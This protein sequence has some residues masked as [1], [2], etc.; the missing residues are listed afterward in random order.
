MEALKIYCSNCGNELSED[1]KVCTRCGTPVKLE[2][3]AETIIQSFQKD[4][5]LQDHWIRRLIAYF[6]DSIIVGAVTAILI[7]IAFFPILLTNA[8]SLVNLTTFPF[9]MGLLY[10]LYFPIAESTYGATFGKNLLGLR[11]VTKSGKKPS[12]EKAF[13]RN[14]SKIHQVLLLLDLVGGLVTSTDL[15]Q[16]YSDRIAG[17]TIV[18]DKSKGL[19]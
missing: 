16:K 18:L 11:V 14:I 8:A 10:I 4:T 3:R 15:Q 6:I 7:G 1:S 2:S 12:L 17:T 19:W 9:G 5:Q 13:I